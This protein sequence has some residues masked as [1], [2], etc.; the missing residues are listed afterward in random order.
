[1]KFKKE[2]KG[3]NYQKQNKVTACEPSQR[4]VKSTES[5]LDSIFDMFEVKSYK[6]R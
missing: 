4:K 2:V 3:S 5:D 1:M 6:G